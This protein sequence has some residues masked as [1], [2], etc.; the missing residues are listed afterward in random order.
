MGRRPLW[1]NLRRFSSSHILWILLG[2]FNN[3]LSAE[4]RV[5]G[6]PVTM[7]ESRDF[8]DCCYDLGLSDLRYSGLFHTWSNNTVWCKLDRAMVNSSW[9]QQ[10][11][12]AHAHFELSSKLSDHS[13][14]TVSILG[15]N[16]RGA[17]P[18]KFFN[19]WTKHESFMDL[20]NIS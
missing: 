15:E 19:M 12:T 2:D 17:T 5:N 7:Y 14:C 1:D 4:D 20:V 9:T 8:K 10:G 16:D 3:V 11:L 13:P 6:L 18:F